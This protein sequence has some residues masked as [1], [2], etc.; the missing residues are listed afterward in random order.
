MGLQCLFI[1][2]VFVSANYDFVENYF[3]FEDPF[4]FF[5]CLFVFL[6]FIIFKIGGYCKYD[7]SYKEKIVTSNVSH[8]EFIY[9]VL[10]F[11]I[12]PYLC[13]ITSLIFNKEKNMISFICI[14]E[15]LLIIIILCNNI[16]FF[17]KISETRDGIGLVIYIQRARFI[18][19]FFYFLTGIVPIIYGI[20]Y[21]GI[22]LF[23]FLSNNS[24]SLLSIL[25]VLAFI[26]VYL[27]I[28][29]FGSYVIEIACEVDDTQHISTPRII[30]NDNDEVAP[31]IKYERKFRNTITDPL[32]GE[33]IIDKDEMIAE[34][35]YG[36]KLMDL[37]EIDT[38]FVKDKNGHIYKRNGY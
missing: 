13:G 37:E 17:F 20:T 28:M 27:I 9:S 32:Y 23:R 7:Y 38:V 31:R 26:F 16:R 33:I 24:A 2:I 36:N 8:S 14:G 1:L 34:D 4:I 3:D 29:F 15:L 12:I 19:V 25:S 11:G 35:E 6:D 10:I 21:G 18:C 5:M 22:S 30:R